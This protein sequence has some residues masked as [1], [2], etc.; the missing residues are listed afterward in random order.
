MSSGFVT[1]FLQRAQVFGEVAGGPQSLGVVVAQDVAAAVE[2]VLVQ[3]AG[4]LQVPELEQVGGEVAGGGQSVGVVV[5]QD[6]AAAVEGVLVQVAGGPH[7]SKLVQ[8][9]GEV[10]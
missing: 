5:A 3:V 9:G 10:A 1:G 7:I 2:G 8:V 4:G 6:V